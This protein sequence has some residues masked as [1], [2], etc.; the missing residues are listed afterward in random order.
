MKQLLNGAAFECRHISLTMGRVL[1]WE[2]ARV[3]YSCVYSVVIVITLSLKCLGPTS[4]LKPI[5]FEETQIINVKL[6]P[7]L[8]GSCPLYTPLVFVF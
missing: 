6:I 2:G 1:N 4:Q 3:F 5:N 8:A 7:K